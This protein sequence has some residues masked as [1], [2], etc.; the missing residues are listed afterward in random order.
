MN[1][2]DL[3]QL[4]KEEI[5]SILS[6]EF[7]QIRQNYIDGIKSMMKR[8]GDKAAMYIS[9]QLSD[10]EKEKL[11]DLSTKELETLNI[12]V[13]DKFGEKTTPLP[14]PFD[15]DPGQFGSLD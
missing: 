7:D 15:I 1:K 8:F 13:A 12:E 14:T 5:K 6:E 9:S 10:M 2:T 3:K 4:I 11:E